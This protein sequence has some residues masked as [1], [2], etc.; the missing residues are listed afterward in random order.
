MTVRD[1]YDRDCGNEVSVAV[2]S[3]GGDVEGGSVGTPV[4]DP[5]ALFEMIP[6]L[7]LA[8]NKDMFKRLL[9]SC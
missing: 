7:L 8:P 6:A 5:K 1:V 2:P 9:V 3:D 4:A